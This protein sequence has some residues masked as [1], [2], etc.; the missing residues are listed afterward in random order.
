MSLPFSKAYPPNYHKRIGFLGISLAIHL[1]LILL[2]SKLKTGIHGQA[3]F[4]LLPYGESITVTNMVAAIK[5]TVI[6]TVPKT[7]AKPVAKIVTKIKPKV[8]ITAKLQKI[9]AKSSK[10]F[11]EPSLT[12]LTPDI[13]TISPTVQNEKAH[14][15]APLTRPDFIMKN[16]IAHLDKTSVPRLNLP[17]LSIKTPLPAR[18]ILVKAI[19]P[20]QVTQTKVNDISTI[21][22]SLSSPRKSI[23]RIEDK[24]SQTS[25]FIASLPKQIF[26]PVST[27]INGI[28]YEHQPDTPDIAEPKIKESSVLKDNTPKQVILTNKKLADISS[29]NHSAS[30]SFINRPIAPKD[31]TA[32]LKSL[33]TKKI[34]PGKR[35]WTSYL[36]D[37]LL[38]QGNVY[39][40]AIDKSGAKWFGMEQGLVCFKHGRWQLYTALDGV[41]GD[42]VYAIAIDSDGN[43]WL[44]TNNGITFFDGQN[45]QVFSTKDGLINNKVNGITIDKDGQKWFATEGGI[46]KFDGKKWTSYTTGSGLINN[47]VNAVA[48]DKNNTKWFATANGV[49]SFDGKNWRSY[50]TKNS[51]LVDDMV[52]ALAIDDSGDK[53]FGTDKGASRFDGVR[54]KSFTSEHGLAGNAVYAIGVNK[55]GEKWFGTDK[56]ISR[57]NDLG[58]KSFG[59]RYVFAVASDEKGNQWFGTDKG[60]SELALK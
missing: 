40:V 17:R 51:G 15:K 36:N 6:K 8:Q 56:G 16:K 21:K 39:S 52:Y 2:L 41:G 48:I 60:V 54:W 49:S 19:S 37:I 32:T 3:I 44:G 33:S 42:T 58:W 1:I 59:A 5:K 20:Q 55:H 38:E 28:K 18:Q 57:F 4:E 10:I 31:I 46:S 23:A 25:T 27:T 14:A 7:Q 13:K 24:V 22:E 35:E 12:K 11:P 43:K 26:N 30:K 34:F 53:W 9:K 47:K 50:T 45:W 29:F